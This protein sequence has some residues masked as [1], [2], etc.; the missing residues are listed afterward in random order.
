RENAARP[1]AAFGGRTADSGGSQSSATSSSYV[2]TPRSPGTRMP[3]SWQR[4]TRLMASGSE[5][6]RSAVVPVARQASRVSSRAA[7]Q[8]GSQRGQVPHR[9]GGAERVVAHHRLHGL[10]VGPGGG[11]PFHEHDGDGRL[12]QPP[13][14]F[15]AVVA[16]GGGRDEQP[17]H[18]DELH[19][20]RQLPP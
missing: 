19:Q 11:G 6:T 14:Q 18:A 7:A 1:I 3:R 15:L 12:P 4:S 8:P 10:L 2:T 17:V 20:P 5:W 9:H 13:H 16:G